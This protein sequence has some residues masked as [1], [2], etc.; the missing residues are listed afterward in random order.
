[1]PEAQ[2]VYEDLIQIYWFEVESVANNPE[3]LLLW[4]MYFLIH[5]DHERQHSHKTHYFFLIHVL[6]D[7]IVNWTCWLQFLGAESFPRNQWNTHAET[8]RIGP[9]TR[10]SISFMHDGTSFHGSLYF[11]F[12]ESKNIF[13][14]LMKSIRKFTK[15]VHFECLFHMRFV[16]T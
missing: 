6:L 10:L 15:N 14:H 9:R 11:T 1:M 7:L 16:S 5:L 8:H 2:G 3:C 13:S 12:N 4:N